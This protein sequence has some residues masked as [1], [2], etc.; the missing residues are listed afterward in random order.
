MRLH[1]WKWHDVRRHLTGHDGRWRRPSADGIEL[2]N[3]AE[4]TDQAAEHCGPL[5]SARVQDNVMA[6]TRK[7]TGG[8][9]A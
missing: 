4:V 9:A 1:H 8:G 5:A 6:V 3:T 2:S 7:D